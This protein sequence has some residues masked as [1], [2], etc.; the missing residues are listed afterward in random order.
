M[1]KTQ[2]DIKKPLPCD[3]NWN[4]MLPT[5]GGRIC[6]GCGKLV[7]DFRKQKW[8]DIAKVH[9]SSP[10]PV[11]GIYSKEQIDS[12]GLDVTSRQSS[13]TKLIAVSATLLAL[14]QFSST[15][16]KAQTNVVQEQ[17]LTQSSK[18]KPVNTKPKKKYV[19][20]TVVVLRSDSTKMP[21]K[22]ASVFIAQDSLRLNTTTD[23]VGRF[24]IDISG[25]FS[26]L[27]NQI[28]LYLSHPDFMTKSVTLNK[29]NLK[30]LDITFSQVT[31]EDE[32]VPLISRGQTAFYAAERPETIVKPE[33]KW[34]QFWK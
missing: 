30:V 5:D 14:S 25:R 13:C 19:S 15:T 29:S 26:K 27:P 20:G 31:I 4:D 3:Q 11:C 28:T 6:L 8:T 23:S 33:K 12:W 21:L 9:S 34:W 22:N 7:S 16:L 24:V 32:R 1:P 17:S 10:I 2:Q 18:Q